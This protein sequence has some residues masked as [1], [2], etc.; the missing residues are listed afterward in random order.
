MLFEIFIQENT[1]QN[2]VCEMTSIFLGLNVLSITNRL[3]HQTHAVR[4]YQQEQ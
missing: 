3:T 4:S 1:L 2:V